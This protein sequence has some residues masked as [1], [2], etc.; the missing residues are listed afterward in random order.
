MAGGYRNLLTQHR[1]N[2]KSGVILLRK[3]GLLYTLTLEI[4][5][6]TRR[7]KRILSQFSSPSGENGLLYTWSPG[8]Y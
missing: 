1:V 5:D 3:N 2:A 8:I 7:Q 6:S 4:T